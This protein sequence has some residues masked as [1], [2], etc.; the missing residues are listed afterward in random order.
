MGKF[1]SLLNL[2]LK[3]KDKKEDK[4]TALAERSNSGQLSGFSGVFRL[5]ALSD[6]EKEKLK[7]LLS[8]FSEEDSDIDQDFQSLAA[9]TSEV[10]AITNQAII[11]HGERIKKA[12]TLLKSYKEGAFTAW[13]MTTYGNRQ[14]PYNFLQYYEFYSTMPRSLQPKIDAMPRQAIYT[15]ASRPGS[16]EIKEEIVK[17]YKGETKQE[18]L[19]AIRK[20]FP[21][22]EQDKRN[23]VVSLQV[24]SMLRKAAS[25]T[26]S[27]HY[28][29]TEEEKKRIALLL[30]HIKK[31]L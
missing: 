1:N 17:N 7:D 3:Q 28:K 26:K 24:L 5:S 27:V 15:L 31:T 12:Q 20:I 6:H 8:N 23:P 30:E 4:M 14:T 21:L 13:L 11:L 19:T 18:I 29:P 22:P 10:K 9:L 16:N 2:R 25:L